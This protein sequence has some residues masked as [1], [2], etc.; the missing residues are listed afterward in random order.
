MIPF[1]RLVLKTELQITLHEL[2]QAG[3]QNI[4]W[5]ERSGSEVE[6]TAELPGPPRMRAGNLRFGGGGNRSGGKGGGPR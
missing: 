1:K 4:A 5:V 3:A 2:K 6:V